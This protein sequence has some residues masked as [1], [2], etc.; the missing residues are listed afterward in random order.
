[1]LGFHVRTRIWLAAVLGQIVDG[2]R[3]FFD[4]HVALF[5]IFA[6]RQLLALLLRSSRR[7][8]MSLMPANRS[9]A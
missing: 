9:P 3:Q 8:S 7:S 5:F 2:C 1:M 6:G 4:S